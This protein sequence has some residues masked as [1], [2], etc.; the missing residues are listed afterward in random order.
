[1]YASCTLWRRGCEQEGVAVVVV[2]VLVLVLVLR[3]PHWVT[4]AEIRGSLG[5]HPLVA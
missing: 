5:T 1:M 2:V 3:M 4:A